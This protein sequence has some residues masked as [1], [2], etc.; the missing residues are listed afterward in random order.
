MGGAAFLS[1]GHVDATEALVEFVHVIDFHFRLQHHLSHSRRIILRDAVQQLLLQ[2]LLVLSYLLLLRVDGFLG[3]SPLFVL[4]FIQ[5]I[6]M[7]PRILLWWVGSFN[8]IAI[9]GSDEV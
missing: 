2:L 8:A 6:E 1:W 4:V 3:E 9:R 5:K 7:V